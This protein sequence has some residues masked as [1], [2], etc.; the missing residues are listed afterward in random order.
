MHPRYVPPPTS[1]HD[2]TRIATVPLALLT[3]MALLSACAS[4]PPPRSALDR[5]G[6]A[7]AEARALGAQDFAPVELSRA[8]IR[9]VAAEEAFLQR[10]YADAERSAAQAVLEAQ[11]AQARS[12]AATL[13]RQVGQHTDENN[14][15]RLDLLGEGSVR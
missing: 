5:A 3:I 14:R 15:L 13:R 4:T 8:K 12:R 2:M 1:L 7:I 6:N 9:F 11:L 10:D